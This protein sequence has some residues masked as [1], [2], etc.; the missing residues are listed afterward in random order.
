M[1]EFPT[2]PV[3]RCM[4][5]HLRGELRDEASARQEL[6]AMFDGDSPEFPPNDEWIF[7]MSLLSDVAAFLGDRLRAGALYGLLLP[8]AERYAVST[9]D[10]CLGSVSRPLG[11]LATVLSRW[12]D[13]VRHFDDALAMNARARP[14]VAET[15]FDYARTL[16][17]RDAPGDRERAGE[18][19]NEALATA[20]ALGMAGLERR[21]E[22]VGATAAAECVFRREGEYWSI[23]YDGD[24]CRLRDT[25]GLRYLALLL[26]RPGR[27]LH[28]LELVATAEGRE[29]AG[30]TGARELAELGLEA[31]GPGDAGE[32][33]DA[34]ARVA[35]K[36]RLDELEEELD[37]AEAGS[38]PERAA[39]AREERDV[40]AAELA[41]ALGLGG[42]ARRSGS[43]AER[44]RQSVTKA[45]K[46]AVDRIGRSC[47]TLA[48]YLEATVHTGLLC[49][50]EPD[51]RAPIAWRL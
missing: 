36:R 32:L 29:P 18:L 16:L 26:A 37:E 25:K 41:R 21:L 30:G 19:R 22:G 34:Q 35:Y 1:F 23:A 7:G 31:P 51:P 42:R 4:L 45:I 8:Y 6:E 44:S 27:E 24:R 17:A 39:R 11:V 28:A 43:P 38:D 33:L 13:A 50:Y 3:L 9:P 47:P 10:G 15:Q 20:R 14:W 49:R 5:A 2:Y 12:D 48:R 46:L 40:I